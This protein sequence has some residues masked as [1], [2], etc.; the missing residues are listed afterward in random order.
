ML[1]WPTSTIYAALVD[2]AAENPDAPALHYQG[3]TISYEELL[4]I[5]RRLASGL[6]D[7]GISSGDTIAVWLSNRPEWI[8]TH[9]AASYLGAAVVAVNTRYRTHEL[10]YLLQDSDCRMLITEEHFLGNDYLEMLSSLIPEL[11]EQNT[12]EF[13]TEAF[14]ALQSI[15]TIGDVEG[16]PAIHSISDLASTD[17]CKSPPVNDPETPACI[18][19][20]SGTTGNPK[21]C[22]QTNTSLLNHSHQ[23][24]EYFGVARDD[25]ALDPMPFCGIMGYN[26]FM[27]ALVRRCPQVILPAFDAEAIVDAIET[28][29]VTYISGTGA[30]FERILSIDGFAREKVSS[31]ESGVV[32]FAN[33]LDEALFER[34]ETE[35]GFPPVQP[36]GLS[37]GN[38]QIFVGNPDDPQSQRK[39]IGGPPIFPEAEEITVVDPESGAELPPGEKGELCL[40]GFNVLTGYL[41]KPEETAAAFDADGWFHTGDLGEQDENGYF[42][43]HSRI[44]DALRVRGFLVSPQEIEHAIDDHEAVLQSQVVG[45][46]HQRHGEVPI[47][48]VRANRELT[49]DALLE[50]LS[51]QIADYKL[52]NS[53]VFVDEFPTTE[54]PNG[55]K[56]QKSVLRERAATQISES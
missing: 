36:Y 41:N 27:S 3:E 35:M 29:D 34:I 1:K 43:Y 9:I 21:G 50:D 24:G 40:R 2:V 23:V 20:T 17:E 51:V 8:Y 6:A 49:E 54:G 53:V 56:I 37:E 15:V 55:V 19:Y 46:S 30:M 22:L 25:V 31:L 18:F 52:P 28:H 26:V 16:Y 10:E 38:S 44:D 12:G 11:C 13:S 39:R 47:A 7:H 5:S 45:A 32:F 42:Y 14:P 48:F 33:G 4:T